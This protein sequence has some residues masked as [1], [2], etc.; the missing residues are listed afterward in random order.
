M[1]AV[2]AGNWRRVWLNVHL[3]IGIGLLLALAPLGLSGAA[4][5]WDVQLDPM[6]SSSHYVAA[7]DTSRLA[8]SAYLAQGQAAF[9]DRARANQVRYPYNPGDPVVVSGRLSAASAPGGIRRSLNAWLDPASG[10]LLDVGDP[11][12]TPIGTLHRLHGN[13]LLAANGRPVVGWLGVAMMVSSLTGL[14]LWWP[15]G[16]FAAGLGWRRGPHVFSNLHHLGGFWICAPLFALSASGV[17]IAFPKVSHALVGAPPPA[18]RPGGGAMPD[19]AGP[20]APA[21]MTPD[22][23]AAAVLQARPGARLVTVQSPDGARHPAWRVQVAGAGTNPVSLSV[24]D[25]TSAVREERPGPAQNP[26]DPL[27]RR[28]RQIHTG[29]E[30]P[31]AWKVVIT[32]A[33]LAPTLLGAS[34]LVIWLRR[35][36]RPPLPT[37]AA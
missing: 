30:T 11:R 24:D 25:A 8:A 34:G 31:L 15:R 27:S 5:V 23:A 2:K 32:L 14:W 18:A 3:W 36:R 1:A 4:L 6:M 35:P 19:M 17:Y 28:I 9:G 29:D 21:H 33:G 7:D 13:L 22:Q 20:T 12:T 16:A 26:A 37:V 10:K